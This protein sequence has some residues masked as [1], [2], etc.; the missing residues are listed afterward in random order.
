MATIEIYGHSDDCIEVESFT[1]LHLRDEGYT[2]A[3]GRGFVELSTGD[4]L[5]AHYGDQGIWRIERVVVGTAAVKIDG[6]ADMD[7]ESAYTDRAWVSGDIA[8]VRFWK[9]WPPSR[10]EID[11]G[12]EAMLED[13]DDATARRVLELLTGRP[14]AGGVT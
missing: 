9:N 8:W 3:D 13:A 1:D 12:I 14:L 2:G 7:D 6:C 4:V 5:S 10:E 11:E